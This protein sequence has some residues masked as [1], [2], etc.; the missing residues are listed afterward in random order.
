MISIKTTTALILAVSSILG[1]VP[2]A[3]LGQSGD[4]TQV[5]VINDPDTNT[6][7]NSATQVQVQGAGD[8]NFQASS[9][10]QSNNLNDNDMN[11]IA[12]GIG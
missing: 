6:W 8:N 3:A 7:V 9:L 11:I 5:G 4:Q 12:Q 1:V 2:I 10:W